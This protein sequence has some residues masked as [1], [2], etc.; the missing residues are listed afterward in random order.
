[1][2][3]TPALPLSRRKRFITRLHHCGPPESNAVSWLFNFRSP[4]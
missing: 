4:D 1:M 3:R 2:G